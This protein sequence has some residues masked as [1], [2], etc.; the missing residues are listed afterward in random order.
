MP[1][2]GF[3]A[4]FSH[5]RWKWMALGAVLLAAGAAL[6][7][8]SAQFMVGL[9]IIDLIM[10]DHSNI[11][12]DSVKNRGGDKVEI[13]TEVSNDRYT[14]DTTVI[15][16]MRSHHWFLTI[17]LTADSFGIGEEMSWRTN[18]ILY[19]KL[20]VGFNCF[21]QI[22]YLRNKIGPIQV[23]YHFNK[24]DRNLGTCPKNAAW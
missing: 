18:N 24:N 7:Y 17:L 1:Q 6:F 10:G 9:L 2:A 4:I 21:F 15:R 23:F 3:R 14:P 22:N 11:M 5:V 13:S 20:D 8:Y 16:T 12:T 19:I